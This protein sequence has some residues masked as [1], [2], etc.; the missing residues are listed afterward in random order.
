MNLSKLEESRKTVSPS[1]LN[2]P[3][4]TEFLTG[5]EE[6]TFDIEIERMYMEKLRQQRQKVF[7]ILIQIETISRCYEEVRD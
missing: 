6:K 4:E 2:E 3:F 1:E 7:E 5:C